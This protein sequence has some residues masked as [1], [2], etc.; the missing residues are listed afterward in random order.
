MSWKTR[1]YKGI[2]TR[3][4]QAQMLFTEHKTQNLIVNFFSP[5]TTKIARKMI[6]GK[7]VIKNEKEWFNKK[8]F[9]KSLYLVASKKWSLTS[10]CLK[11]AS[12]NPREL[13]K[14][15]KVCNAAKIL[16]ILLEQ[17]FDER[18]QSFAKSSWSLF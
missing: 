11:S 7:R 17:R 3:T 18:S 4:F 12:S 16:R 9:M 2:A 15:R 14:P 5:R 13:E 8:R 1:Y 6:S 10:G